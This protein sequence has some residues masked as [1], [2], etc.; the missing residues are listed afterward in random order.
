MANFKTM[1][2]AYD[3]MVEP[4]YWDEDDAPVYERLQENFDDDFMAY[5]FSDKLVELLLM[6]CK[7]KATLNDFVEFKKEAANWYQS[8]LESYN[9]RNYSDVFDK[10]KDEAKDDEADRR[11]SDYCDDRDSGWYC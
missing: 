7:E 4:S 2:Q 5:E 3:N 8:E 9:D 1:Q 11:F 6:V 10:M